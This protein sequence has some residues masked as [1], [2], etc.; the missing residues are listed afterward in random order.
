[1]IK[2]KFYKVKRFGIFIG[3]NKGFSGSMNEKLLIRAMVGF[4]F[5]NLVIEVS[6]K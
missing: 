1:M 2:C 3:N 6:K 4:W 5:T